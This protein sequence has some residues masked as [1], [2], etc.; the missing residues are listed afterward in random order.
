[1]I[2]SIFNW[3]MV[4]DAEEFSFGMFKPSIDGFD[5]ADFEL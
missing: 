4:E 1:M 2:K 3:R 5:G